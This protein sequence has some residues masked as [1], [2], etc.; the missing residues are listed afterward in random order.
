MDYGSSDDVSH[1]SRDV[2]AS[3]PASDGSAPALPLHLLVLPCRLVPSALATF[4][5]AGRLA[6][7]VLSSPHLPGS[8]PLNPLLALGSPR[9]VH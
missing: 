8:L 5:I 4:E 6:V 2:V 1:R 9:T 3:E 7:V